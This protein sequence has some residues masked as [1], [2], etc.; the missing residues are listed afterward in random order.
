MGEACSHLSEEERQVIRI[1][2]GNGTSVRKMARLPGRSPSSISR[3]IRRNMW[4]PVQRE[5]V[6]TAVPAEASEASEDGPVDGPLLHRRPR[7]A[8]GRPQARQTAQ[9][10]PPVMRPP[11]VAGG[12]AGVAAGGR[13][14]SRFPDGFPSPS[15]RRRPARV[16]VTCDDGAGFARRT[17]LRDGPGMD[18]CFADPYSSRRR[19]GDENRNGMIRRY[20][21]ERGEIRMGMAGELR[22]LQDQ[23]RCCTS[24]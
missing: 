3:E 20:P 22:E 14:V 4:F 7:A 6:L 13:R 21:P 5:R 24:K 9:A 15:V 23:Q 18:T 19:G 10:P 2:V 1:E 12:G 17:R 16:A 8:Q 11:V